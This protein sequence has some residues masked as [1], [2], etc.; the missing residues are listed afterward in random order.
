MLPSHAP[1]V[2][3]MI[4]DLVE[5]AIRTNR[6]AGAEAHVEVLN[7]ARVAE[8]S[9]RL[10]VLTQAAAAMTA[11]DEV[12]RTHFDRVLSLPEISRWPFEH[13]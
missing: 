8:I 3:W 6:G 2:L 9:P 7:R 1:H 4:L 10:V 5:A 11:P 12:K 13:A